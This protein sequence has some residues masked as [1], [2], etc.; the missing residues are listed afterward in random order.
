MSTN[1][2]GNVL[3]RME[4]LKVNIDTNYKIYRNRHT[5]N[6]FQTSSINNI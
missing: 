1:D 6:C 3:S 2:F 5:V 4:F